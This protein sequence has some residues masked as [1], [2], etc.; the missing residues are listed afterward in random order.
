MTIDK[1]T[2]RSRCIVDVPFCVFTIL[3]TLFSTVNSKGHGIIALNGT[4]IEKSFYID[5][6]VTHTDQF[7]CFN[8]T[9]NGTRQLLRFD[10]VINN[11]SNDSA[12]FSPYTVPLRLNYLLFDLTEGL[13]ANQGYF[14]LSCIRDTFCYGLDEGNSNEMTP[15]F[16]PCVHSGISKDC[17]QRVWAPGD[18]R[19][20]DITNV[21]LNHLFRLTLSLEKPVEL[22]TVRGN[23]NDTQW[24]TVISLSNIKRKKE[25]STLKLVS[26]IILFAGTPVIALIF[27]RF[28]NHQK[29]KELENLK[30]KT[31]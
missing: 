3:L 23:V 16:F 24:S 4:E 10:T 22:S 12:I 5:S 31:Q 1:H 28:Y 20:I 8:S 18:C 13:I 2:R 11:F 17:Q 7:T 19:W 21:S 27:T 6:I 30:F 15:F 29:R 26:S 9:I 14:N 25:A